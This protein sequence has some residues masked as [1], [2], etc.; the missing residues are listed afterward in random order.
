V[1][2]APPK[3]VCV[4]IPTYNER[5]NVGPLVEALEGLG[6]PGLRVLF[7][8]DG[9]PDGTAEEV[10]GAAR[11]RPWVRLMQRGKKMG[12]GSAYQDGFRE[13]VEEMG[14]DV[15]VE[16][17]ADL[18]HPASAVPLLVDALGGG[19]DLAIGSRYVEGGGTSG[20]GRLRRL[21][22]R[23]ANWYSRLMLGLEVRDATSG[24]RAYTR[25]A[26]SAVAAARL[27]AKG[28]EFQVA[29]LR[30]LKDRAKVVEVPYVFVAR[31][32]G[33]SKLGAGDVVRF[34]FAVAA[35]AFAGRGG[36]TR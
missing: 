3:T 12:I 19:A 30:L 16:M 15:V 13:A 6:L 2:T 4:V 32:A 27:P 5:E 26:A 29:V 10:A 35:M 33:K 21:T 36:G 1:A 8:D 28:F 22:S 24:L 9:S 7:V 18:Q 31:A 25:E 14:A 34:A 20:W 23:V 17:D 11:T